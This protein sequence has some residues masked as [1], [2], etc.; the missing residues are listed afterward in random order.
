[1]ELK[2]KMLDG[3]NDQMNKELGSWYVYL[4]MAAYFENASLSGFASWMRDQANEERG[5]AMKFYDFI[6]E[7][8]GTVDFPAIGK[9]SGA[10]K[11]PLAAFEAAFAHERFI[12][13]SIHAL[14]DLSAKENDLATRS[15]LKWFIDEQV[16]EESS[17]KKNVDR[18]KMAGNDPAAILALDHE[19]G[20]R[21]KD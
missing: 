15:F 7:R 9:A 1:M 4:G 6:L 2:K 20:K 13:K 14:A 11:S 17:A 12:T 21:K 5:H 18:L 8:D 16:E 10:W 3:L 19:L